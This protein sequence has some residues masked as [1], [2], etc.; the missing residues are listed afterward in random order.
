MPESSSSGVLVL[1]GFTGQ[2]LSVAGLADA[3]SSAGFEVEMPTLP[4]HGTRLEDMIPTRWPDWVG[5]ALAAY[6]RLAGRVDRVLVAA[7]SMGA[8]LACRVT[9]D[10][11]G[12]VAGLVLVNPIVEPPGEALFDILRTSLE[13]GVEVIAAIGSDIAKPG[14]T[15]AAY[16]GTA[17]A[18]ALSMYEGVRELAPRLGEITCPVLLFN[19]PQDHVVPPSNSDFLAASVSGPVERVTCERSYHVATLDFDKELIEERAVQFARHV[20]GSPATTGLRQ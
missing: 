8:A 20:V 19:S 9:V 6:D 7:L 17:L 11:P 16:D 14:I 2:P 12:G 4:G 18:A 15:E 1:H 13:Q 3:F 10:R 5:E